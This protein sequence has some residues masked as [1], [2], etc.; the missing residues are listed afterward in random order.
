MSLQ[1]RTVA[2]TGAASG[3]GAESARVIKEQGARVIALDLNEPKEHV[4]VF[5]PVDLS[6]EAS[7]DK[8]VAEIAGPLD[9]LANVAGIPPTHP[10]EQVLRVNFLGLRYLTEGLVPKLIDGG[11]VVNMAS[12][13][14]A[15]WQGNL[16]LI[17]KAFDHTS[18]AGA[19]E[20]CKAN[21][22]DASNVYQ[23][24]KEVLLAWTLAS[25]NRWESR[26]IR[27]N[28]ISPGPV[29]T[30]ILADFIASFPKNAEEDVDLVKRPGT[31]PEIAPAVAFLCDPANTWINGHNLAVDGGLMAALTAKGLAL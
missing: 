19:D 12:G 20:F 21:G 18:I 4:D 24:T 15:G 9:A 14:G 31:A 29:E 8:A 13:L 2:V 11:C 7:I 30:P 6:K 22:V 25:W 17:R 23:F 27:V 5:V 28:A 16:K 10:P 26:G 3:I 1:G